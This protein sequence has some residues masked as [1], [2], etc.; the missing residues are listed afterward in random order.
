MLGPQPWR[1]GLA[2]PPALA[3][4]EMR[5][6]HSCKSPGRGRGAGGRSTGGPGTSIVVGKE[7]QK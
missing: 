2:E 5:S 1:R 4:A 3:Q 6:A 7:C